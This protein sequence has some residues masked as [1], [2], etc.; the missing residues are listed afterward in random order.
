VLDPLLLA[1]LVDGPP[2]TQAREITR[3]IANLSANL[4]A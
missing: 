2:Q 1:P 4:F 3:T